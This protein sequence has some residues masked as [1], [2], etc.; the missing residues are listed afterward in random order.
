MGETTIVPV[1]AD[2]FVLGESPLWSP[3]ERRLYFV[4]VRR[5]ALHRLE[6]DSGRI[7]T[8]LMP[9]VVAAVVLRQSGGLVLSLRS[10]LAAFDPAT[11]SLRPLLAVSEGQAGN[12]L[13]DTR[14]DR[15][16]RLWFGTMWDFGRRT[17]GALYRVAPDLA[18]DRLRD[19]I[20]IPNA[21]CF[22][23]DDR[24]IYFADTRA[25]PL[26]AA[27]FD[28]R[29]GTVGPWREVAAT[30][31]APG[32]PDGATVDAEGYVW[33]ARVTG[34]CLARFAPDGRLDRIVG[35]PATMPTSCAF[36]GPDLDTLFVTTATQG[37]DPGVLERQPMEGRVLA[38]R[39]GVRGLAEPM[40]RG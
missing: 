35:L 15:A 21:L 12:R 10:G 29:T 36:G 26:E 27:D 24:T 16:G 11:G 22:S 33:N 3:H 8:W 23:P 19:G 32:R 6:P 4:D 18:I 38:L 13:N 25:G 40:F 2:R 31:S 17:T 1:T 34:G 39:P 7:D 37:L 5:P 14:C 28:L 9:E 20:T 30:A